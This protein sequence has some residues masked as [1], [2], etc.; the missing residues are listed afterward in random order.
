[1]GTPTPSQDPGASRLDAATQRLAEALYGPELR[2]HRA[3][4]AHAD[5]IRRN[6][7]NF[8]D[9]LDALLAMYRNTE[10]RLE[11][12]EIR[13]ATT[14]AGFASDLDQDGSIRGSRVMTLLML[15]LER[16]AALDEQEN[17][18]ARTFSVAQATPL[19]TPAAPVTDETQESTRD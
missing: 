14:A 3:V 10:T 2:L 7:E 12:Q 18:R 19:G 11:P 16:L 1:M 15:A 5:Y 17:L 13:A 6:R 8:E 4:E 9:G